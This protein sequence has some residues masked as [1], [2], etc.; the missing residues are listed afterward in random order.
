MNKSLRQKDHLSQGKLSND[1]SQL[2]SHTKNSREVL[3][4]PSSD[5]DDDTSD[6]DDFVGSSSGDDVSVS[7]GEDSV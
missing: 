7:I 3:S 1:V 4:T 2:R 6:D 5:F